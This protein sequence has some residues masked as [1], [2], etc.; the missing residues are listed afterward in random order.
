M[1][2]QTRR[3]FLLGLGAVVLSAPAVIRIPGLLMPVKALEATVPVF[4]LVGPSAEF[5]AYCEILRQARERMFEECML[6]GYGQM[7]ITA[8]PAYYA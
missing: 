6:V 4:P 1:T 3:G 7:R 2:P 8:P 5:L